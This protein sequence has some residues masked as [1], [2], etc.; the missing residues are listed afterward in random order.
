MKRVYA[1]KVPKKPK[2]WVRIGTPGRW[3]GHSSGEFELS[4][5]DFKQM[6]INYE[7]LGLDIV[8]DYEHAT[9]FNPEK[10]PAAGWIPAEPISL[11]VEDGDLWARIEWTETAM[12]HIKA[13][14]YRYL[15]PVFVPNTPDRVTGE[16]IGWTLHSVALTNTPFLAELDPIANREIKSKPKEN[17]MN[18]KEK[19]AD[20]ESQ[21]ASANER[22]KALEASLRDHE[23]VAATAK[24]DAAISAGKLAEGQKEWALNYAL[25][26][27]DGFEKFLES[28]PQ[29]QDLSGEQFAA[30]AGTTDAAIAMTNI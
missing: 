17:R 25:S 8:V 4:E 30:N 3:R 28:L 7:R 6:V 12:E 19:I 21:L 13:R 14:E 2:E 22:I 24:I 10:A 18:D 1:L 26:D 5:T 11:K 20:L 16:N 29:R 9:I 27:K 23:K 15:S